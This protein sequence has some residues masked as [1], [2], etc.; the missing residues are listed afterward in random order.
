MDDSVCCSSAMFSFAPLLQ[1]CVCDS[2]ISILHHPRMHQE[3]CTVDHSLLGGQRCCFMS[4]TGYGSAEHI[5]SHAVKA[6]PCWRRML[7]TNIPELW[8]LRTR[9]WTALLD[10][11]SV[12]CAFLSVIKY[13]SHWGIFTQV[14][15]GLLGRSQLDVYPTIPSSW[16]TCVFE[17]SYDVWT[18]LSNHICAALR[19]AF[20]DIS[21]Y[22]LDIF[23]LLGWTLRVDLQLLCWRRG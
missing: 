1:P 3:F 17:T 9:Q 21:N 5:V 4:C 20:F 10:L 8:A 2:V 11:A 16:S 22:D 15:R 19:G 12:S 14:L 7:C 18:Y 23:D 6:R 13:A